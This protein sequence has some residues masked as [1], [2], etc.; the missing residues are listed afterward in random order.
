MPRLEDLKKNLL[1]MTP[2]EL[3]ARIIEIRNDRIIRKNK[4]PTAKAVKAKA[5]KKDT[6]KAALDGMTPEQLEELFKGLG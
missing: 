6:L 4:A 5:E 2:E 1:D 3:R